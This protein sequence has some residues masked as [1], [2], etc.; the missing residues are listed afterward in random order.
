MMDKTTSPTPAKPTNY[1]KLIAAAICD[2]ILGTLPVSEH[3]N[4][5]VNKDAGNPYAFLVDSPDGRKFR[6]IV[7][8]WELPC[9]RTR[10]SPAARPTET[11][12]ASTAS[13]TGTRQAWASG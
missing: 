8:E 5:T 10:S 4:V 3:E 12:S 11:W 1:R 7:K 6:V 13:S 9:R 2:A